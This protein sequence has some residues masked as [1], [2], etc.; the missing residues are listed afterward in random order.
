MASATE[1]TLTPRRIL[2]GGWL[3]FVLFAF[4]GYMQGD[5]ANHLVDSRVGIFTD[6]QS[7]VMTELCR[8]V[9]RVISGPAGLLFVQSLLILAGCYHLLR[10]RMHERGAAF[11]AVGV[12]LFPTVLETAA[13]ISAE[14]QVTAFLLAGAA[15]L[16][17]ERRWVRVVGVVAITVACGLADGATVAALPVMLGLFRW[18]TESPWRRRVRAFVVWLACGTTAFAAEW[19]LLDEI[20]QRNELIRVNT[21]VSSTLCH[22]GLS[23]AQIRA[24]LPNIYFSVDEIAKHACAANKLNATRDDRLFE[25]VDLNTMFAVRRTVV[26]EAPS[27]YLAQRGIRFVRLLGFPNRPPLYA[28]FVE[29]PEHEETLSHA[30]SH[31]FAQRILVAIVRWLVATPIGLPAVYLVLAL[32]LLVVGIVKRDR[33]VLVLTTSAVAYELAL[34]FVAIRVA[35][36]Y[37]HWMITAAVLAAV[38]L[39]AR[40]REHA[41]KER[42]KRD[43]KSDDDGDRRRDDHA[44][45][46]GIGEVA[47]SRAAPDEDRVDRAR[48]AGGKDQ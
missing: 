38:S 46:V 28:Q 8:V 18:R 34:F 35:P 11:A 3:V 5:A 29:N 12:L 27:A 10:T 48:D 13:L 32:A 1:V 39:F 6:Y 14:A 44:Q 20:S 16:L 47:V 15:A 23:D 40:D 7:P 17:S 2:T 19:L 33:L 22:S 37:S 4:P 43:L 9:G 21:D 42:G 24:L 30:A 45:D 26:R 41:Q 36:R 31:S 25:Q